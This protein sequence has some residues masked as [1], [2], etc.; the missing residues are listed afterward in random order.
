MT[1]KSDSPDDLQSQSFK[2]N[3]QHVLL[4]CLLLSVQLLWSAR[5]LMGRGC[6]QQQLLNEHVETCRFKSEQIEGTCI[7]NMNIT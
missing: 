2:P 3:T 4:F 1:F 5:V 6:S 7:G